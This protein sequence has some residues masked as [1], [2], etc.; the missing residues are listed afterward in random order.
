MLLGIEA[1]AIGAYVLCKGNDHVGKEAVVEIDPGDDDSVDFD[2]YEALK[3]GIGGDSGV[4]LLD[5]ELTN[6]ENLSVDVGLGGGNCDGSGLKEDIAIKCGTKVE[7]RSALASSVDLQFSVEVLFAGEKIGEGI[8]R[9]RREAQHQAAEGSL[10]N[11]AATARGEES[12]SLSNAS[13]SSRVLDPRLEG[14]KKQWC[15]MEGLAVVFQGQPPSSANPIQKNEVYA[16]VAIYMI[17][18]VNFGIEFGNGFFYNSPVEVDVQVLGKR[19]GFTR[20]EAK[21]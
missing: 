2:V 20:D 4:E 13:D 5:V 17:L 3:E 1:L 14:S 11:L 21:M 7:F 16:Q 8:D 9:T 18:F 12:P 10:M 19:I 6:K 15:M